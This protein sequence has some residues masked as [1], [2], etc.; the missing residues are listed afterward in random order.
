MSLLLDALRRAEQAKRAKADGARGA[1]DA[2]EPAPRARSTAPTSAAASAS[3]RPRTD[4]PR[5]GTSARAGAAQEFSLE[6]RDTPITPEPAAETRSPPSTSRNVAPDANR[7]VARNVFASKEPLR[8]SAS[9]SSTTRRIAL[10]LA[11]TGVA[12]LAAALWFGLPYFKPQP[13][14]GQV[15][16]T[17]TSATTPPLVAAPANIATALPPATAT[18]GQPGQ[19]KSALPATVASPSIPPLLPPGP[20]TL[21]TG[22]AMASTSPAPPRL[23]TPMSENASERDLLLRNLNATRGTR[24]SAREPTV[25]LRLSSKLDAPAVPPAMTE[26]YELLRRGD[27]AEAQKRYAALAQASPLNVDAH[28]GLATAAARSG[29]PALARRAYQRV[30]ELDPR[31]ETAIAGLMS[32]LLAS[33]EGVAPDALIA[34]LSKQVAANPGAAA[35]HFALGNAYAADRRWAEAQQSYFEAYRLDGLSADYVY[36]LAVSLDQLGQSRLAL[37]HYGKALQ[38][39]TKHGAQFDRAAASR[40]IAELQ[41]AKP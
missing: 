7:E 17:P 5:V 22:A 21:G 28:L 36:N 19:A 33:A 41:A 23:P 31:N 13:G 8:G 38:A 15:A 26:A 34:E 14:A 2:L 9:A 29:D 39:A 1:D 30:L 37:D 10:P 3:P 20:N 4:A 24:E 32:G 16:A 27:Y 25:S 18:T 11:I 6:E 35:L 12:V 40:R